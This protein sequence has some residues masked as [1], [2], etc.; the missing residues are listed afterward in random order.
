[1]LI[2]LS[3]DV[4]ETN[5]AV[6]WEG[7]TGHCSNYRTH[8]RIQSQMRVK[9][10]SNVQRAKRTYEGSAQTHNLHATMELRMALTAASSCSSVSLV[11]TSQWNHSR[12]FHNGKKTSLFTIS[13]FPPRMYEQ[14]NETKNDS[15]MQF[16]SFTCCFFISTCF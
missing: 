9:T 7:W 2:T 16:L 13:F 15:Y 11:Q 12:C 5:P 6:D 10:E 1:M 14:E 8:T 4:V 3:G